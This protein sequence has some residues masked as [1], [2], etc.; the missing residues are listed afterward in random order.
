M[1]RRRSEGI[2][3]VSRSQLSRRSMSPTKTHLNS[4]ALRVRSAPRARTSPP[5]SAIRTASRP[6]DGIET[7]KIARKLDFSR[8][9][10]GTTSDDDASTR[11][12]RH[13]GGM[14]VRPLGT[15]TPAISSARKRKL[16]D[17]DAAD[18][19][20]DEVASP[21]FKLPARR[22]MN[23]EDLEPAPFIPNDDLYNAAGDEDDEIDPPFEEYIDETAGEQ[24]IV[25]PPPEIVKPAKSAMKSS[26]KRTP[27]SSPKKS[28]GRSATKLSS[29]AGEFQAE[30]QAGDDYEVP[31]DFEPE[32]ENELANDEGEEEEGTNNDEPIKKRRGRPPKS[33]AKRQGPKAKLERPVPA[34]RSDLSPSRARSRERTSRTASPQ[35]EWRE[36]VNY[37]T[38]KEVQDDDGLRKSSRFKIAPLAFWRGEKMVYGRGSRRKSAGGTTGLTLPEI[39]EIIHVDLVEG[40]KIR[41]KARSN[42]GR[43]KNTRRNKRSRAASS[44]ESSSSDDDEPDEWEDKVTVEAP[45][46]SFENPQALVKK[47]LA[48]PNAAY[49]PRPVI[50]QGIFFQKTL[51]EEPHFAAGVLDIPAGA[52][53]PV[54]PSKQNTMFFFIFTGYVQVKIHDVVFRLRKGGQFTV[55]RGNFYEILN[56]GKQDARLFFSQSTDTLAN[57]LIAHPEI[58]E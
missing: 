54:K 40:D 37:E 10:P 17:L 50:N 38:N 49:D 2:Q 11:R 58:A 25:T 33:A 12:T 14:L 46:R 7:S 15:T 45:I 56:V 20:S 16:T 57:H 41:R 48:V 26:P 34:A 28:P 39:K 18:M 27:G 51:S 32:A 3:G 36:P 21:K 30:H 43:P 35:R 9:D 53:K 6:L 8:A 22:T 55:P 44:E 1:L 47:V 4:P 5:K 23:F 42:S 52:G 29:P 24:G 31:M 19:E 13:S